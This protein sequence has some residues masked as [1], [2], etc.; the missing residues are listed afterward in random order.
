[1]GKIMSAKQHKTAITLIKEECSN[2]FDG[3]CVARG[4]GCLQLYNNE[5]ICRWFCSCVLPFDKVLDAQIKGEGTKTCSV[6]GDAFIPNS[7][8]AKYC[9]KC[10][11]EARKK[12]EA[13]RQREIYAF[14]GKKRPI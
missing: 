4:M 11:V 6:C 7:N 1:M 5:I 13:E 14:R 12:K 2:Y 3:L 8:R 10:S 9:E